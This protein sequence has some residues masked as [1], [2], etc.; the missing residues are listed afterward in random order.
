MTTD[1]HAGYPAAFGRDAA[2]PADYERI[3]RVA[4]GIAPF[5]VHAGVH[6]TE[7]GPDRAVVEIPDLDHLRNHLDT[8][9]A[10]ALFLAADI[11]GAAA[12]VGAVA[13]DM[14]R[15]DSLVMRDGRTAFRR[16]ARGR[17]RAVGAV[18]PGLL[19]PVLAAVGSGRHDV[20]A[21]VLAYDDHGVLVAK[22]SFDYVC[23]VR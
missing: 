11:A 23:T 12:F 13:H 16:P 15:I 22:F 7:L 19:A 17:I 20:D 4:D 8:V 5:N 10:G 2:G 18:D 21:K 3:R 6:I 1:I 9:H 14:Q